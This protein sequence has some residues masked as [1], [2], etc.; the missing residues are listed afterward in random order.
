L[1]IISATLPLL[2]DEQGTNPATAQVLCMDT[3][4]N[5]SVSNPGHVTT[6]VKGRISSADDRDYYNA[7]A[8]MGA[9]K[10]VIT[11]EPNWSKRS[12]ALNGSEFSQSWRISNLRLQLQ[13]EQ[14]GVEVLPGP[15]NEWSTQQ[16]FA[17]KLPE[18]GGG[19]TLMN[20]APWHTSWS[21][22]P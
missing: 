19:M 11:Y 6:T 15:V 7:T 5:P 16:E 13:F 22:H 20:P 3:T 1:A 17:V 12:I 21:A 10:V 4:C 8:D 18:A 9:L 14:Q 2:A